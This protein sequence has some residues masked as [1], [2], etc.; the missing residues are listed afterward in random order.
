MDMD[1]QKNFLFVTIEGG[2]N[3]P[4]V[5]GL[6]R[7]LAERG[8][9]VRVL[10]EPCLQQAVEKNGL[11]FLPFTEYF[12]RSD[13]HEDIFG[14]WKSTPFSNPLFDK[15]IFGPAEILIR[16]IRKVMETVET[17]VL[18]VDCLL[19]P[20]LIAA[21][22]QG[23][24][25]V[26]L[27]HMPEYLPGPNRPPGVMGLTPGATLLGRWRDRL[28]GKGFNLVFNKYLSQ[29]NAIRA[30]YQLSPL[31]NLVDL[32]HQADRRLIQTCRAFDFPIEPPPANVRYTGPV[33]EDPDWADP[34]ENPW[35]A[36][37]ARP[38][39]V[40]SFSST[41]QNQR[42]VI[43][44][45]IAALGTLPVR[46]LVTLGPALGSESFPTPGN[47][48]AVASASH[49]QVFPVADLVITHAGHGTIMRALANGLPLICLPMG[50]DQNDNAAKVACH[51]AGIR[52]S[53]KSR[54]AVIRKAIARILN[55][56]SYRNQ[57]SRLQTQIRTDVENDAALEE[58]ESLA[59]RGKPV[60]GI[61]DS[62]QQS[63]RFLD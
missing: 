42:A 22:A 47:V 10:A 41:F 31:A 52:L 33:L 50:R 15:I 19:F 27:F 2:G 7:R 14:D 46:A 59:E 36:D 38:L 25:G 58:L 21:E 5:L 62:F 24:P 23:I 60:A 44:R 61:S 49:A 20:A 18:A 55:D 53:H 28:L 35:P 45:C 4:P 1:R 9:R 34:W 8:H 54:P 13:R 57:A 56:P 40:V 48:V 12:T 26:V 43:E 29:I 63:V 3:I 17:D 32:L 30:K 6:A 39:V 16:Q 51:G 37:D 11:A